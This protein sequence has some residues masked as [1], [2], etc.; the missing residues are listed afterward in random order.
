MIDEWIFTPEAKD[1]ARQALAESR[2]RFE[3]EVND[4]K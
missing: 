3:V 2:A 1:M 4:T